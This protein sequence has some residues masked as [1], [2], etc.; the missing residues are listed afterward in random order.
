MSQ[1]PPSNDSFYGSQ[2][3]GQGSPYSGSSAPSA[4][5]AQ[6][7]PGPYA[8]QQSTMAPGYGGNNPYAESFSYT[9]SPAPAP[10]GKK[11]PVILLSIALVLVIGAAAVFIGSLVMMAN[12]SGTL[13]PIKSNGEVTAD[14][15]GSS[16]YAL[17]SDG[18]PSCTVTAPDGS[19]VAVLDVS[20]SNTKIDGH[21]MVATF[22][23]DQDG[24]H[25][26]SCTTPGSEN[27]SIGQALDSDGIV[28]G[29]LGMGVAIILAI[30]GFPMFIGAIIW[31]AVRLSYNK[32]ARQAQAAMGGGYPGGQQQY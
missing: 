24:K 25:T 23:P 2:P 18:D 9:G 31:L 8:G 20:A 1:A 4:P 10:K 16:I 7:G 3:Y 6:G 17:Y 19:D 32:K 30:V 12:I 22:S 14:L 28:G 13:T 27:V 11:G 15:K 5:Y 21:T 26:I 29:V